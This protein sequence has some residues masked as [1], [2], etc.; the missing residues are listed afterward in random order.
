MGIHNTEAD[1][2]QVLVSDTQQLQKALDAEKALNKTL[3]EE[4]DAWREVNE[5]HHMVKLFA[6]KHGRGALF[7]NAIKD[8]DAAYEVVKKARAK[9]DA[10]NK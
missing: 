4:V 2:Y 7:E 8:L 10:Q 9:T 5:C 3:R 6:A 1:A